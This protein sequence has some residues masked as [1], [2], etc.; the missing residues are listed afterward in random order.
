MNELCNL[1]HTHTYLISPWASE[2]H[3]RTSCIYLPPSRL[4]FVFLPRPTSLSHRNTHALSIEHAHPFN[5][6]HPQPLMSQRIIMSLTHMPKV[7]SSSGTI[8][9]HTMGFQQSTF[10]FEISLSLPPSLSLSHTRAR[11]RAHTLF[12]ASFFP[13]LACTQF[14]LSSWCFKYASHKC[15]LPI[16]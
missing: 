7:N 4:E 3:T 2:S 11:A 9:I 12:L 5:S 13:A 16:P 1:S 8:W 15:Y 14:C 6:A 10:C